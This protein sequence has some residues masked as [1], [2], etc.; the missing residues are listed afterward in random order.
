MIR[1]AYHSDWFAEM[2]G[3]RR[4]RCSRSYRH[5][6]M[7]SRAIKNIFMPEINI[8]W[9]MLIECLCSGKKFKHKSE[10]FMLN[11]FYEHAWMYHSCISGI[12]E[13]NEM[14][15]PGEKFLC[16]WCL[17]H[18]H[19]KFSQKNND[20]VKLLFNALIIF[21]R[22]LKKS[23]FQNNTGVPPNYVGVAKQLLRN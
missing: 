6:K 3:T 16:R 23:F 15:W 5:I 13:R 11:F 18:L 2:I 4:S 1:N 21:L 8:W 17:H 22:S 14:K 10:T 19:K 7:F 9:A 12:L 20:S